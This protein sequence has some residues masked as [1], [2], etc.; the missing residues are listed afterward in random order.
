MKALFLRD[1]YRLSLEDTPEPQLLSGSD[2]IVRVTASSICGSD[3]HFWKGH[4]PSIPDFILGHEFVGIITE[5]GPD[6][7]SFRAGDRV[8]VPANPYCGICDNCAAG[9]VYN[10]LTVKGMFGAGKILGDLPGAQSHFV[11]VP[12]ADVCLA[13]IPDT[14]TDQEALLVGDVLSTGYF[15][16]ENGAPR[17]GDSVAIFGAGPVGLCAAACANLFSPS[18]VF[19]IDLEDYRLEKGCNLGAAHLLNPTRDNVIKEIKELT[20]GVGVNYT[21][22]ATGSPQVLKECITCTASG[23]IISAV[24]IGAQTMEFPIM[25]FL[26]KNLTLRGGYVPL[27]HMKRL[28]SLIE[29]KRLDVS[30]LIT[31]TVKLDDIIEGYEMFAN[32]ADGCIKVMVIP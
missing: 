16:V 27:V 1:Q 9:R 24:G 3:V 22:D 15:A 13:R 31:H 26:F 4:L 30:S 10:C 29:Q 14:V 32:K 6:V 12:H 11:R 2:V 25:K 18:R 8:A 17:P 7:R 23:G 28:L 21:I 20:K 5:T 19:L